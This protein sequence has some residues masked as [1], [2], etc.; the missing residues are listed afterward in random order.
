MEERMHI[1]CVCEFLWNKIKLNWGWN[2][3]SACVGKHETT[4][5]IWIM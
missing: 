5:G 1:I 2:G 4:M 3:R